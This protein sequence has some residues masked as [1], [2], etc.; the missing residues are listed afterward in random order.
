MPL[1]VPVQD[2]SRIKDGMATEPIVTFLQGVA[3]DQVHWSLEKHL[4]L[5]LHLDML[6]QTPGRI[7][8]KGC[9]QIDVAIS[10]KV[11]AEC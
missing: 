8:S 4:K 2:M 7:V 5:V 10:A 3:T 11:I 9:E 1:T 6:K